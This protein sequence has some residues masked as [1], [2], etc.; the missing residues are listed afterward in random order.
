M[1]D[2][3]KRE[4]K[5]IPFRRGKTSL[6]EGYKKLPKIFKQRIDKYRRN[7]PNFRRKF[8]RYEMFCC[9]QAVA[10]AK[11]VKKKVKREAI[12]KRIPLW[13]IT[14]R[15]RLAALSSFY[16]LSQAE[17]MK[18]VPE[19]NDGQ[20]QNMFE[21][22]VQLA[23]IYLSEYPERVVQAH[24]ALAILVGSLE[25]GDVPKSAIPK[26]VRGCFSS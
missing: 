26:G 11:A 20:S 22:S 19:L 24:G 3:N 8:E 15:K 7:N 16:K 1:V 2:K 9:E 6:D 21:S 18:M 23:Y 4:Q 25:Y 13:S 5:M 17:Q 14:S 12:A 10:I